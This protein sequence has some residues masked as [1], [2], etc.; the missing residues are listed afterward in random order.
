MSEKTEGGTLPRFSFCR[1]AYWDLDGM[2]HAAP[3]FQELAKTQT[4]DFNRLLEE[5]WEPI[6]A[7]SDSSGF[8]DRSYVWLKKREGGA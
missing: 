5:G 7:H 4:D 2:R 6:A 8:V 1:A 3:E